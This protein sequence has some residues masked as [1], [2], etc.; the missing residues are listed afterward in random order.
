VRGQTR[1]LLS[2]DACRCELR[3]PVSIRAPNRAIIRGMLGGYK[4]TVGSWI[5]LAAIVV[6]LIV[7]IRFFM[8]R[9]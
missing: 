8:K 3:C 6:V 2:P 7:A 1:L 5:E 4:M 9:S